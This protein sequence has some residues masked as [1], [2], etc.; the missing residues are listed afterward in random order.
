MAS[1]ARTPIATEREA[2]QLAATRACR[3]DV[4]APHRVAQAVDIVAEHGLELPGVLTIP[5]QPAGAIAFA[6]GSGSSRLR[7]PDRALARALNMAGLATLLFDLL[8]MPEEAEERNILDIPLLTGRLTAATKWLLSQA[9]TSGLALG[10]IGAST[11]AAAALCTAADLGTGI[12]A[13]VVRAPSDL[14]VVEGATHFFEEPGSARSGDRPRDRVVQ[15]SPT[16]LLT[17]ATPRLRP[18]TGRRSLIGLKL[19]QR[20]AERMLPRVTRRS[21]PPAGRL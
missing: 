18:I 12:S 5:P 7:A 20:L 13:I 17:D 19:G 6:R 16:G 9:A 15:P 2:A 10:F 4:P 3:P 1:R 14:A 8:T 21:A 11:G